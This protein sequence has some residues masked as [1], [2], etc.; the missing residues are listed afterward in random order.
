MTMTLVT[1]ID[2][3]VEQVHS[4]HP[5]ADQ[6]LLRR[7]YAFSA[8]AHEGQIRRS[9]E[10]YLQHPLA[11]AGILT[12]LKLDMTAIV[13]GLLHDTVEDTV[14]TK[15]ELEKEF[16]D[17]VAALVEGVTKIGQIPFK[18]YE[19]KQAENFRKMLL[20][21]ADDIRVVFIKLADRLHNMKTLEHLSEGKQKQIA[22][23]TL[24]IYAP[25]A[26]RLGMSWMKQELEDYCFRY[27]KPEAHAM[28]KLRVAKQDEE[29][30]EYVES[31]IQVMTE[32]LAKGG[33]AGQVDGRPKHLYS[34][35]KKIERQSITFDEVYDLAAIRIITDTKMNCYTI[36]G[37]VHSLW[38]PVPGR[39]KDYIATPR[40]NLYQSLHTS[41]LG[42]QGEHVEFQI[43]TEDMHRLAEY[44][45][46]AHW[47]Y[48]EHG[49]KVAGRDEK[50]F[51]WLRQFVEWHRDL[52]DNRQFMDSVKLDLFHLDV[53][54]DV[55]FAFTPNGEVKELPTGSTPVD[56]AFSI[57][58]EIGDHCVGAKVNGKIVPLRHR[59]NSGDTV[60]ILTSPSQVPQKEWL[61]F[62]QTSRARAKIKHWLKVDEQE[63]GLELGM[64]LLE[65]ECRRHDVSLGELQ[66]S[67][68]LLL[69]AT[70]TGYA[71][72]EDM[73]RMIGYG[74]LS[75][76]QVLSK[77]LLPSSD[78][79]VQGVEE[80]GDGM[81]RTQQPTHP[82]KAVKVFGG[83][84]VL[85]QLSK[86]CN[87]I[88]GDP[89]MGYITRGRG[90]TIHSVGCPNLEAVD[91]EK[92]RLV[93]MEW[94]AK[95]EGTHSVKV[96]V[97]TIDRPG[98]LA[99]VSSAI[100]SSLANISR[101]E[102][103]TREDQ[104][105]VLDFVVEVSNALHLVRTLEAIQ[106]VDGVVAARRVRDW[107][108]PRQDLFGELNG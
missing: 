7:A 75:V 8:K 1:E 2:Q 55:V 71:S 14:A 49:K 20:S 62:V 17:D 52:S 24:E 89:I 72:M 43:R 80:M 42:P 91:Y 77:I 63:R 81:A 69:V 56:F 35:Y 6:D 31:V 84:D 37:V 10:P 4:F 64:A 100:S 40:T 74:R 21:M 16:G 99:N 26:N 101:A 102:I 48:K 68:R 95:V 23:E 32:E 54:H 96:C 50:V 45:I 104:K 58:T 25:L 29:R 105:A 82:V 30:Q 22:Q 76:A 39:F 106:R 3:L 38:P 57:H 103:T 11:V 97:L 19:E 41:V 98:V 18:S 78:E 108:E 65:R 44:G 66:T 107:V 51:S 86:C 59:L 28:L 61:K 9:G 67:G 94:D 36:L 92:D 60:H 83:R 27:L 93:E 85:M 70:T 73:V 12:F 34:I 15:E 13:A 53:F 47:R 46:A 88:P 87:P 33:L 90:L 5:E 79:P